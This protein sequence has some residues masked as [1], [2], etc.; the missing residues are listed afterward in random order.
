MRLLFWLFDVF[1]AHR[2][3]SLDDE[4][5]FLGLHLNRGAF[6]HSHKG[7]RISQNLRHLYF[8]TGENICSSGIVNE[9]CYPQ[10]MLKVVEALTT[11]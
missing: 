1:P 9:E 7:A 4:P 8:V 6:T 10:N 3:L 5:E 11:S 2:Q